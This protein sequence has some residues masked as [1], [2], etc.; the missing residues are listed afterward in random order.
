M[1]VLLQRFLRRPQTLLLRR[2]IFQIHLCVGI[3]VG[4]YLAIIG[5]TGS[6]LV[7]RQELDALRLPKPWREL[8]RES[9]TNASIV[10]AR[11]N[12]RY[13]AMRIVSLSAPNRTNPVFVATLGGRGRVVVACDPETGEVL[14]PMPPPAAWLVLV[15]QLH[16]TL[17]IRGSGRV[18]NG[19]GAAFLLMLTATGLVNWWPGVR[20]WR[21]ALQVDFRFGWRRIN[22]DLHRAAGFWALLPLSVWAVSGIYFAWTGQVVELVNRWSPII[23]AHPPTVI[24]T[25]GA[26][27]PAP[28]LDALISRAL[29]LD[30]GTTWS[31]I[32]FPFSSRAPLEVIM[33]RSRGDGRE[34]EDT[35]YFNPYTG[36]HLATWRYGI[37]ESVGDW[38]IWL[39]TPLHFGTSWGLAV[40]MIWATA[41]LVLPLLAISGWVMYW[42]RVLRHKLKR[43]G[44]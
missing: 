20:N 18:W 11:V 2:T 10:V 35:V 4:L 7:F 16:E 8:P 34:Y 5:V 43:A 42:N 30:P 41:G 15:R 21:R 14:G 33:R 22:F 31:S 1:S 12:A 17:L 9:P 29:L 28:N 38:L 25:P 36:E 23:S 3:I 19:F 44:P 13:P 39:Q 26:S 6:V 37:N 40:K 27:A 32:F 24:A